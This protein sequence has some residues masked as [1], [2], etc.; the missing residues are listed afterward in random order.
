[1][2]D[3]AEILSTVAE[4]DPTCQHSIRDNCIPLVSVMNV[5]V[6]PMHVPVSCTQGS[7]GG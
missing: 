5:R 6:E 3:C 1:V 4:Q 7:G 2:L